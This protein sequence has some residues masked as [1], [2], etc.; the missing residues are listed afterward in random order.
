MA[1]APQ[2]LINDAIRRQI[3]LEGVK[4]SE[5]ERFL[6]FLKEID[7]DL[8]LKLTADVTDYSRSRLN[9]QIASISKSITDIMD[10]YV[11]SLDETYSDLATSEARLE[12]SSLNSAVT[13]KGFEAA[14]PDA[15]QLITAY[16]T[17]PISIRGKGQGLTLD[18]FT[19]QFTADQVSLITGR[20][21]QGFAEGQTTEQVISSLRGTKAANY[22]DGILAQVDR[23][24]KT[25]VRTALQNVSSAARQATWEANGDFIIGV[26]WVSTL[27]DRTT[28]QCASL[29]GKVFPVDSGPR[30]PLHPNCRSTTAPVLSDD[31][32]YL[33]KGA[34]R[35]SKGD[36]GTEQVS[37]KTTYYEW[38]GGQPASFQ[39]HVLGPT[40]G[41]LFRDGGLSA[42]EFAKLQ[43]NKNYKPITIAEMEKL[44]PE[45]F[46][47]AGLAN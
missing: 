36:D 16:K 29:D 8:R 45:A 22:A 33:E 3:L 21:S 11:S 19:K 27:D 12:V 17:D 13:E 37:A 24:N 35:P 44:A 42:D 32:Q 38:L 7:K 34:K 23:N 39:D 4:A 46:E 9:A 30:P 18:A 14:I 47:K 31:L 28:S 5:A 40:K 1:A 43:I 2:V 20:I 26:E 6:K 41:K 10:E 15:K 25:M